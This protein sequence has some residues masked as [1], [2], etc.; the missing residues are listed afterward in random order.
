[1]A[2]VT[3]S[4]EDDYYSIQKRFENGEIEKASKEELQRYAMLLCSSKV[5]SQLGERFYPQ[6]CETVR[7]LLVVRMSEEANREA[8]RISKIAL[9]IAV[10]ALIL[11]GVQAIP[12][13]RS[14]FN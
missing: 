7:T 10:V 8:T 12:V 9:G 3:N 1:M 4:A 2:M 11:S 14:F 13:V 6:V 5:F